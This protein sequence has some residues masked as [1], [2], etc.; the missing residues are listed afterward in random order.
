MGNKDINSITKDMIKR[1]LDDVIA[2]GRENQTVNTIRE[3]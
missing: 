2:K 3:L 1:F